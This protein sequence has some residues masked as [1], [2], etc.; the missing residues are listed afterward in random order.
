MLVI[1][2]DKGQV[3][4]TCKKW[5]QGRR[6]GGAGAFGDFSDYPPARATAILLRIWRMLRSVDVAAAIMPASRVR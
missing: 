1:A 4:D 6:L 5:S 2:L 3:E